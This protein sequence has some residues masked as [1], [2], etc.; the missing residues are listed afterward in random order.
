MKKHAIALILLGACVDSAPQPGATC[1]GGKCDDPNGAFADVTT[2]W[3]MIV[4]YAGDAYVNKVSELPGGSMYVTSTFPRWLIKAT[5]DGK[6]DETFGALYPGG[7]TT[8][9]GALD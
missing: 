4:G 7:G 6:R 1:G 2:S 3:E 8:R 9:G 5:A